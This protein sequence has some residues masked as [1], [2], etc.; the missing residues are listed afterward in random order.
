V[1]SV[2]PVYR[3]RLLRALPK[4][5]L[6]L[7]Q[8]HLQR[9]T[10][11]LRYVLEKPNTRIEH[12]YF[13]EAGIASVVIIGAGKRHIEVGLIGVEGMSGI[14]VVMGDDRSPNSTYIQASGYAYCLKA[15]E[16][17]K[18]ITA[19]TSMR[20][21]FLKYAQTFMIQTAQTAG[22][23]GRAKLDQR[24]ARWILMAQD[25][26]GNNKL[27]LTHDFLAIM[28]G[29]RR[30]GVTETIN[31][32]EGEQLIRASRGLIIVLDRKGLEQRAGSSYGV[33]EAEYMRLLGK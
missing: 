24:L 23:N 6:A 33:P 9:I 18:A 3:N 7:L 30:P 11:P 16:L 8:P 21:L 27:S 28:L 29:V 26:L 32:L 17:K 25:R 1:T 22:A 20:A 12:V 5:D 10:L 31:A 19:S 14:S 2:R 13:M 4:A 15:T